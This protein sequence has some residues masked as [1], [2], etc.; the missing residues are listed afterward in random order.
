MNIKSIQG[1]IDRLNDKR[2]RRNRRW[3]TQFDQRFTKK[4][5]RRHVSRL[6]AVNALDIRIQKLMAQI[7]PKCLVF[8]EQ[9]YAFAESLRDKRFNA[10]PRHRMVV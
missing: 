10:L 9:S 2:D 8:L 1:E 7:D 4:L 6:R 5:W 3:R